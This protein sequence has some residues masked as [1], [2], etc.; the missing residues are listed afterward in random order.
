M[1]PD[2]DSGGSESSSSSF[3]NHDIDPEESSNIAGVEN[4]V[5]LLEQRKRGAGGGESKMKWGLAWLRGRGTRG[6]GY[7]Y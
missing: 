6:R 7:G 1:Y 2:I 4:G 3:D 5:K